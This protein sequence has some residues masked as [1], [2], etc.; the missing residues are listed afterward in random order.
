MSCKGRNRMGFGA[1]RFLG[2][3]LIEMSVVLLVM[4]L[5]VGVIL[6]PLGASYD[7]SKRQKTRIQLEEIREALL[8]FAVVN[9]RL[10]CPAIIGTYGQEQ[11]HCS[12]PHGY[13]PAAALGV[14][15]QFNRSGLLLDAWGNPLR[16]SVSLSDSAEFGRS[17]EADFVSENEIK[18]VGLQNLHADLVICAISA[19]G[20]CARNDIR[21]NHVPAVV[22]STGRDSTKAGDQ[23]ENLDNDTIFASHPYSQSPDS[24]YDDM[25]L[26]LSDNVLYTRMIEAGVLP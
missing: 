5:L 21:A 11:E 2:F 10:P 6:K 25:V 14:A 20:S 1:K 15:G 18:N 9:G 4:G 24:P 19:T 13:L 26:W 7:Q 16:Y 12:V 3:S 23:S 17:G 8:G 22:F